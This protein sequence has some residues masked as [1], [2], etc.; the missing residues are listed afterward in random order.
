MLQFY[1]E[2]QKKTLEAATA[3]KLSS[4]DLFNLRIIDE[5]IKE[6][7]GGAHRGSETVLKNVRHSIERSLND[8]SSL[9]RDEIFEERKK[10]FLSIGRSKGFYS[11]S[12]NKD[13]LISS[14]N[15]FENILMKINK[16]N[17]Y[18]IFIT[19]AILLFATWFYL[20]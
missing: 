9:S 11:S 8:L 2:I 7:I 20:K 16:K 19:V 18:I 14:A 10:K 15:F 1:G 13:K 5:I 3:M 6:P 4:E 12:R 17:R